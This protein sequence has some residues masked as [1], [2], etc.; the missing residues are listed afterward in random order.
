[1]DKKVSLIVPV[2][3]AEPY[4]GYAITSILRQTYENIE[5]I[6]V[7]DG[8]TDQSLKI[9]NN[10]ART[11][12]RIRVIDMPNSGV[13][14]ARNRGIEEA[15]GEYIQFADADDV[16]HSNMIK[17]M[18]GVMDA[19]EKDLAVCGFEM[20]TLD[21]AYRII[22]RTLCTSDML[23][24]ECVLTREMFYQH[25]A[26]ILWKSSLLECSW[27]KLFRRRIVEDNHIRF[28]EELS[29]GEDFCFNMN[30]FQ[31][32][33]GVVFVADKY[34]YYLQSNQNSLTRHYR[35]HFFE[36]QLFLV[37]RFE[38]LL[39]NN[40]LISMEEEKWLCEYMAEK[41]IQS[42]RNLFCEECQLT[43]LEKKV[44]IAKIV[45]HEFVRKAVFRAEYLQPDFA[46]I[47]EKMKFSD[48]AGI[49]AC[50]EGFS[51]KG[52]GDAT[53]FYGN[54]GW[55]NRCMVIMCNFILQ[56]HSFQKV[57]IVR[58]SIQHRGIKATIQIIFRKPGGE[59]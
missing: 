47:R 7:N 32:I 6:L 17:R 33:N 55:M 19:Y 54:A 51:D 43:P 38:Q 18:T 29:L 21:A 1:M 50:M 52:N 49:Y 39:R 34:Y 10:Y 57:E 20:I 16:I 14:A 22:N 56:L 2:Y 12:S 8:S 9:C 46:W 59:R 26:F 48:V 31:H 3:N 36:I 53:D 44:K 58:N 4:L 28:P 11:D 41:T 13:S 45:N 25:I 15:T 30:Y 23:G 24:S 40:T 27:N 35:E 37:Q 42:V 5:L